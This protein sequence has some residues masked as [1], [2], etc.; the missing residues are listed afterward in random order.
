WFKPFRCR[1]W[2]AGS[3]EKFGDGCSW[4]WHQRH[5]SSEI[6]PFAV[7]WR[8]YAGPVMKTHANRCRGYINSS[9]T[10]AQWKFAAIGHRERISSQR[11]SNFVCSHN[12]SETKYR[13]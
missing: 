7:M 13:V 9:E 4:A 11:S 5:R 6:L 2:K 10:L 1:E 8:W 12:R 3:I